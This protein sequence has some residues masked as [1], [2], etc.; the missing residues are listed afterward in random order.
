VLGHAGKVV[1]ASGS[2]RFVRAH[3]E[4][5]ASPFAAAARAK[6]MSACA[7]CADDETIS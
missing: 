7:I 4:A 5:G 6:P 1:L 3:G 2:L